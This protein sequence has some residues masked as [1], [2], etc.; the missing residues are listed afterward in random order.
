MSASSLLEQVQARPACLGHC[1]RR[2]GARLGPGQ[3]PPGR[4]SRGGASRG[5]GFGPLR[6]AAPGASPLACSSRFSSGLGAHG[7]GRA[8]FPS[9]SGPR[10]P[11]LFPSPSLKPWVPR[12]AAG[13]SA[14]F[15]S[16]PRGPGALPR[17]PFSASSS[18][19]FLTPPLGPAP[20]FSLRAL[21]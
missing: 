4:P 2:E 7:P 11:S 12:V 8:A 1:V 9:L 6:P 15:S 13:A 10:F 21:P 19:P 20:L 5:P 14:A 16:L 3:P 17:L 18:L